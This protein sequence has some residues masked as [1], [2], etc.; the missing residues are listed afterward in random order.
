[1]LGKVV[2]FR[3]EWCTPAEAGAVLVVVEDYPD[4]R[5]CMVEY[6]NSPMVIAPVERVGYEMIEEV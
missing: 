6:L 5:Q 2:K 4:R 3:P 1:M